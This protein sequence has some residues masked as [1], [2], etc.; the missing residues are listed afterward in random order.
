MYVNI[1]ISNILTIVIFLNIFICFLSLIQ[2]IILNI[3]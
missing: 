1:I 2:L 3:Y